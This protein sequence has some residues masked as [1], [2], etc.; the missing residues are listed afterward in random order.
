MQQDRTAKPF[1]LDAFPNQSLPLQTY[2][3][4]SLIHFHVAETKWVASSGWSK[5][6]K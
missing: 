2:P 4:D 5:H 1:T 3:L 6:S